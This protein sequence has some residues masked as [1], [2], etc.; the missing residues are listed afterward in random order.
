MQVLLDVH[1]RD[2]ELKM[3]RRRF[4]SFFLLGGA[5]SFLFG[6]VK[7]R[8]VLKRASFWKRSDGS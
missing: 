5:V 8:E 2:L 6:K 4:I 3:T 1:P 7:K